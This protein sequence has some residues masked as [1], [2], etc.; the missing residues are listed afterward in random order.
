[1]QKGSSLSDPRWRVL[2]LT[3]VAAFVVVLVL[4]TVASMSARVDPTPAQ[5]VIRL[6]TRVNQLEQRLYTMEASIRN[7]E[8]QARIANTTSRSGGVTAND[9]SQL[10][11]QLQTLQVRV[12]E[13]ECALAKLDE[14][15]L[16]PAM[17]DARRK[18]GAAADPC[19]ANAEAPLRL[20]ERRE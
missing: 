4:V 20:P 12:M 11:A 1:M 18:S 8:Q 5:D 13:D 10:I 2:F 17:R 6:E 7:I 14:R 16:T 19:R 9:L 3:G 15:T